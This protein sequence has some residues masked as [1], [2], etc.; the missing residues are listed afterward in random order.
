M[1]ATN[2]ENHVTFIKD[3]IAVPLQNAGS[4]FPCMAARLAE[5]QKW[6]DPP[7]PVFHS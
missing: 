7:R 1:M 4:A 2:I 6:P 3:K 5:H